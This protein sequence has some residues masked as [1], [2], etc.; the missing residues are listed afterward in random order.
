MSH[1]T[2]YLNATWKSVPGQDY[3]A[4]DLELIAIRDCKTLFC[5]CLGCKPWSFIITD[6]DIFLFFLEIQRPLNLNGVM[7]GLRSSSKSP[8]GGLDS[9][10]RSLLHLPQLGLRKLLI[11][12][13][14]R[15]DATA[16]LKC[17]QVRVLG[18][19]LRDQEMI[20]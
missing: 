13:E 20:E 16:A 3:V 14:R 10:D 18:P 6:C 12:E 17:A 5:I 8:L 2:Q 11:E 7:Q 9:D 19:L 4:R 15:F 1:D